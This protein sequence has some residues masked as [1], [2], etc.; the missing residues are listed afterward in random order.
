MANR[1]ITNIVT[2]SPMQSGTSLLD[3]GSIFPPLSGHKMIIT[4]INGWEIRATNF[5]FVNDVN[6]HPFDLSLATA[7]NSQTGWPSRVQYTAPGLGSIDTTTSSGFKEFPG[8][9]KVVFEDSTNPLNDPNW[10]FGAVG[11]SNIVYMWIYFGKNTTTPVSGPNDV[12]IDLDIDF[13]GDTLT[14]AE[15]GGTGGT[16]TLNPVIPPTINTFHI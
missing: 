9:Y 4:P 10:D 3:D 15:L 11:G 8:V 6:G 13:H 12:D 2:T 5:R 14:F 7:N 16:S 1:Y